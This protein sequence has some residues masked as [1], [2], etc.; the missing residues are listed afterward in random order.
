MLEL[1]T[2][3]GILWVSS[4]TDGYNLTGR[5]EEALRF[6]SSRDADYYLGVLVSEF[7][8]SS[9]L[10]EISSIKPVEHGVN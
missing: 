2:P 5:L 3:Y 4:D 10:H 1:T 9:L 7:E 8:Q 6:A